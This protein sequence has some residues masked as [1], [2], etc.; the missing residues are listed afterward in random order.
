LR[1]PFPPARG[2]GRV[3]DFRGGH[4]DR[5]RQSELLDALVPVIRDVDE[6]QRVLGNSHGFIELAV[7]RSGTA[8]LSDECID[9]RRQGRGH[10]G[11]LILHDD[12]RAFPFAVGCE[13]E[14]ESAA[15]D[16]YRRKD[17]R[18]D[19][20]GV[21]PIEEDF[22]VRRIGCDRDRPTLAPGGGTPV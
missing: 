17:G 8:P 3:D 9:V 15:P 1:G 7:A 22:R 2:K 16:G 21:A 13:L 14:A 4:G 19:L 6:A 11:R 5:R 18:R 10:V 20:T 12:D